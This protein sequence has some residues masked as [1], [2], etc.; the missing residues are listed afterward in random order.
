MQE[1][2]RQAA[3][4][5]PTMR[6]PSTDGYGPSHTTFEEGGVK[7]I[8]GSMAFPTGLRESS[9]LLLEK[10]VPAEVAVGKK[11]SYEYRVINLTDYHLSQ[12]MVTDKVTGNFQ[13]GDSEPPADSMNGGVAT[14][15]LDHLGPRE[16]KTIKVTGSASEESTI[17]TCGWA[18]YMPILC[19]PIKVV[20][21]AIE[22]A[23]TMP[24]QVMQ[25]DPIPVKLT[26]RNS[27][28]SALTE[29]KVTDSL[30]SGL[31]TDANQS[32]VSFDVGNLAPGESKELSFTAKASNTGDF[33]NPAKATSAQGVE[34][35]ATA[36]VKVVKPVLEIACETPERAIFG[37][38]FEM[39]LTVRNTGD[40]DSANTVLNAALG[41]GRFVSATD[42]GA[43]SG[44]N[45][46][47]NLGTLAPGAT[48]RVCMTVVADAG[49]TLNFSSSVQ[50]VCAEPAT[51]ACRTVVEGVPGILLEVVDDVDPIPVG[52]TTTYSIRVT[53][54][55][56]SPISNVRIVGKR[57]ADSQEVVSGTGATDVTVSPDGVTMGV[58]ASLAPK[59]TVEWKVVVR[60]TKV[61]NALFEVKLSSDE[62]REA[63][64]TESTN[65]Y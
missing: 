6:A 20:K 52:S 41:G 54:Q 45:V 13:P 56:N 39:C 46:T 19:E 55:G 11:F 5:Q 26:V 35:E 36:T 53:N 28:S 3:Q 29:V 42:G 2:P 65:Q 63:M 18:T 31:V 17:V 51:T 25:C 9:G 50:G 59:Q 37:R 4:Q 34:A 62:L 10:V 44:A 40:G 7:Y 58:V 12:V 21:P 24:A 27:G 32:S 48:K 22:L 33:T 64:E 30:P 38:N 57:D 49:A 47:W 23:K 15:N 8:R 61:E 16:T 1:T 14:W 60:A 43:V